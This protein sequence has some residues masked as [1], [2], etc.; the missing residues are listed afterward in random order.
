MIS[1]LPRAWVLGATT[2]SAQEALAC[3]LFAL[4]AAARYQRRAGSRSGASEGEGKGADGQGKGKGA[5]GQ[6]R[7]SLSTNKSAQSTKIGA[8]TTTRSMHARV[9]P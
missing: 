8:Y 2:T 7:A 3:S 5:D 9:A 6:R 4:A 1:Q